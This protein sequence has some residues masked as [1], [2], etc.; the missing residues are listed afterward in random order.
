M[1][2]FQPADAAL[3]GFRITRENPRALGV[4]VALS[5]VINILAFAIDAVLPTGTRSGLESINGAQSLTAGQLIDASILASPILFFALVVM[6]VMGAAIYRLIFRHSEE[7]FAYLRLGADEFR[8]MAVLVLLFFLALGF[9]FLV[10]MGMGLALT[11]FAVVNSNLALSLAGPASL[12]VLLI[13]GG[14]MIRF[15]L[16]PVATFAERRITV[17]ESWQLTRH[18]FW[19]LVGAYAL[20]FF[21]FLV[22]GLL[23]F[24]IFSAIG[25]VL[26]LL[27][28]GPQAT[29]MRE[30]IKPETASLKNLMTVGIIL[31][32]VLSSL[33]GTLWNV[34]LAAPGAVAYRELHGDPTK[35][36]PASAEAG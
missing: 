17:F 34:V 36:W 23:V 15:S 1:S 27:S 18:Q 26:V 33:L 25:G 13:V 16:A 9:T 29:P 14:L 2:G 20:A 35:P 28:G 7:R 21:C 22:V 30:L 19:P 32:T 31:S 3:E 6:A 11:L 8:L 24:L 12:L 4:W 5:F 10:S